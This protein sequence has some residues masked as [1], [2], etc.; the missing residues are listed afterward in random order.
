M[1]IKPFQ[2]SYFGKYKEIVW[3]VALF[4]LFDLAVLMLNFYISFQISSD[5]MA[6]NLAGRQRMLSQ[7]MTKELFIAT[8]DAAQGEIKLSSFVD[9]RKTVTLF[10]GT[11]TAFEHG[12]SVPGGDGKRVALSAVASPESLALVTEA[13]AVWLPLKNA[14]AP[15]M[16]DDTQA[17]LPLMSIPLE[18]AMRAARER[19]IRLL[20]LMNELTTQLESAARAKADRLR[21]VQTMGIVLALLNFV[22]ILFKFIARLRATDRKVEVAQK[23]T[24]D[25][26]GT[27]K[28]GLFLLDPDFRFGTQYSA[29]LAAILGGEITPGSDFRELLRQML[30]PDVFPTT[31]DYINLLFGDRVKESLVLELNPLKAIEV[32]VPHHDGSSARRFLTLQ[33]NRVTHGRNVAYLL[34]TVSDVTDQVLLERE[35]AAEKKKSKVEVA[36]LLDLLKVDAPTLN[37]FLNTTEKTL[38]DINEQLRSVKGGQQDYRFLIASVFRQIHNLKGDA[39]TLGLSPFE[40]LAHQFETLLARLRDKGTVTGE[41]LLAVPLPLDELFERVAVVRDLSGR[42]AGYHDAF[43]QK[44]GSASLVDDLTLLAQRIA[45][46]HGKEVQV[47]ADLGPLED[48]PAPAQADIKSVVVQLLRNAIVHGIE[49]A[50]ERVAQEKSPIGSIYIALKPATE[51]DYELHLRDDGRGLIPRRIKAALVESGRYTAVQ[52][53]DYDDKQIIMKIFDPGFSTAGQA[54]RDAGHGVGMDVVKQKLLR[55]GA[56]LRIKTRENQYTQF[57]VRFAVQS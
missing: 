20:T 24:A 47:S 49:P 52:L 51:G 12:G 5:A 9:L 23:E 46:D 45:A 22:F 2:T 54:D 17:S 19:N 41:D 31:V 25:I 7:R 6:I 37:H 35:L 36:V 56:H 3:A 42:L 57:S 44:S 26:L 28:E 50:G 11:L 16:S 27:V 39:A 30:A 14:I 43:A 55:L 13:K 4:L 1:A 32:M 34:V 38:L 8:Q 53:D 48:L 15:F 40:D 21:F 29:S 18:N 10:D 33:F